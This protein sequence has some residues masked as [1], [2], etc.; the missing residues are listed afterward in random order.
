MTDQHSE[1]G[2][3]LIEL[4]I[5]LV[6]MPLVIGAIAAAIIISEQDSGVASS[7]LS[8]SASAQISSEYYISDVQGAA[9]VTTDT[10]ASSPSVCVDGALYD[11]FY[12]STGTIPV[13]HDTSDNPFIP[14]V[15][16]G[17][18]RPGTAPNALSVGYWLFPILSPSSPPNS[19]P[20]R[21]QLVRYSCDASGT[22]TS[23]VVITDDIASPGAVS[24]TISGP[25][26]NTFATVAQSGWTP[27][28]V[29]LQQQNITSIYLSV[30]ESGS[31]Y[32]WSLQASPRLTDSNTTGVSTGQ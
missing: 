9:Q 17:L 27:T 3:T 15:V 6:I 12:D 30:T 29:P 23:Q 7:R 28:S 13:Y 8:D 26:L 19:Q 20:P 32:A 1:A 18:Y 25:P 14:S 31:N 11:S 5:V 2:F 21:Y 24:A 22:M 10:T 4:I 16:L